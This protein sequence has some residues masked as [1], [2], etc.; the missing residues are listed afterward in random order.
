MHKDFVSPVKSVG[1][2][3]TCTAD[4]KNEEEVYKVMF[5]LSQ[6]VGHRLRL[7]GLTARGVQI[8]IRT[9]DLSGMQAQ[10]KLPVRTQSPSEITAAGFA[11]FKERY[12]WDKDVRAV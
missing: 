11:L 7:H 10:C 2:G 6:D 4:L 12:L 1:H 5:E 3:I 8:W 9:N